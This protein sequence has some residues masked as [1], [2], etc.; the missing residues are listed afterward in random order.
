MLSGERGFL[1]EAAKALDNPKWGLWLGR[2]ACIPGEPVLAGLFGNEQEALDKLLGGRP[3]VSFAHQREVERFEEGADTLPD[4]PVSFE[5]NARTFGPRRVRV[6]EPG[7][8]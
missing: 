3:L 5:S 1:T 8:R 7:N 2:K 6:F 4:S